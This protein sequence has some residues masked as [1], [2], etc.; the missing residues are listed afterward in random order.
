MSSTQ[1]AGKVALITGATG[2]I[3]RAIAHRFASEGA[4]L[5]L[6]GRDR[7]RGQDLLNVLHGA[8]ATAEFVDGD[9]ELD[10]AVDDLAAA[11]R[12]R[13]GRVDALV[14]NAGAIT[15]APLTDI[16]TAQY[17]QMMNVNVRAPWMCVKAMHDLI[18]SG[19]TITVTA[20]VSSFTH[21]PGEGAY[22][23]SKAALVPMVR[24]LAVELGDRDIRV[25]ALCPGIVAAEGMSQRLADA[26]DDP[27][28][29][30]A[31]GDA[32]TPLGRAATLQEIAAGALFLASDQSSFMTGIS[33]VLDGG[34]TIPRL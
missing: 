23:M 14:L 8:G 11:A 2:G 6:A 27:A 10:T 7:Q 5:L 17:D 29:E 4:T 31:H 20:S 24:A 18:P 13:H 25:N 1:L 3:G 16:T 32:A 12:E 26:S 22:C 28:A 33:L 9:L 21:F 19:G 30:L 34:L 15:V